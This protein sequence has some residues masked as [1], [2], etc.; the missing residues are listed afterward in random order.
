MSFRRRLVTNATIVLCVLILILVSPN[1]SSCA[2]P[3]STS[4]L[5]KSLS[6]P[7][8][9]RLTDLQ[10]AYLDSYSI[11]RETNSCSEFFGGPSSITALNDF[12]QQLRPTHLD[13]QVGIRMTGV[14]TII[15]KV[16][17]GFSYRLFEKAEL[18]LDGPFYLGN[19]SPGRGLVFNVGRY[20]P[21]TREARVAVL[22]HELGHL[23]RKNNG[24]WVLPNDGDDF[25]V[26]AQNTDRVIAACGK[27]I[28]ELR[29]FSFEEELIATQTL[30]GS[31]PSI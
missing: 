31:H 16:A 9:R 25:H 12:V 21:N 1:Q 2:S 19:G 26:S 28:G 3:E 6:L 30:P 22:L 8:T 27:Q 15:R 23:I 10:K 17:T 18:N 20:S 5:P 14:T 7:E 4:N 13:K 11:L 24:D 29:R